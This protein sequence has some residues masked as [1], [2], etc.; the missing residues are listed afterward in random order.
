MKIFVGR[1]IWAMVLS[2]AIILFVLSRPHDLSVAGALITAVLL[3]LVLAAMVKHPLG[4]S[5]VVVGMIAIVGL[6][7]IVP[8]VPPNAPF[9]AFLSVLTMAQWLMTPLLGACLLHALPSTEE[10]CA[11]RLGH[12]AIFVF[13]WMISALIGCVLWATGSPVWA[14]VGVFIV[15]HVFQ[16]AYALNLRPEDREVPESAPGAPEGTSEPVSGD[17]PTV[18]QPA[19]QPRLVED[20]GARAM[21]A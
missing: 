18:P 16:F 19:A 3:T 4:R 2:L 12:S 15:G 6:H 7:Q 14:W 21:A 13:S 17:A 5:V 1:S 20:T 8:L 9:V 11:L 10:N